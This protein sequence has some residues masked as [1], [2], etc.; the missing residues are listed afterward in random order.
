MAMFNVPQTVVEVAL[1][2]IYLFV[3]FIIIT[4]KKE[5][6]KNVFYMIF[7]A[8]G[9]ADVTSI[10]ICC[11]FRI[12]SQLQ[13]GPQMKPFISAG[14]VIAGTAFVAHM[15][16]NLI[17]TINRFSVLCLRKDSFWSRK[18]VRIIICLQY[19]CAFAALVPAIGADLIY[20][21]ND[22]GSYILFGFHKQD[23]LINRCAYV[24]SS[25]L[26]AVISI[27]LNIRLLVYLHRMM[28]L[29]DSSRLAGHEKGMVFCTLIVFAF[30][31]LMCTQ[32]TLRGIAVWTENTEF[33]YWITMHYYWINDVMV[34][35]PPCTQLILNSEL[36]RDIIDFFQCRRHRTN[37]V[38]T[39]IMFSNQ[40][41]GSDRGSYQG[42]RSDTL[43]KY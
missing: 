30:T 31:M 3:L 41:P 27:I 10:L 38:S 14:A 17:I 32:Q 18:N 13:L 33:N 7:V 35:I 42:R 5:V 36:R 12:N 19:A 11:F 40:H 43:T 15:I 6:F 20:V 1:A 39:A 37:P 34:S 2:L 16:G 29:S 25:L 4:S 21:K 22:D 24:G 9:F 8:T 28:K 26:Y 23:D